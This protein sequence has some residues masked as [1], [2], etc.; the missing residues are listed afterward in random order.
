MYTGRLGELAGLAELFAA[1]L[2]LEDVDECYRF[3][4]DLCTVSELKAM[5]QRFQVA[6]MLL[7]GMR[8]EDIE[9]RTGA[10]SAT[11]SRVK[12]FVEYGSGGYGLVSQRL[13]ENHKTPE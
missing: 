13:L 8:Y 5:S 10:S 7:R 2:T 1:V 9:K 3:F 6:E 11:I 12:R 4:D